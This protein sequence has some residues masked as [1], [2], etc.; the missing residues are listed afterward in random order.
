MINAKTLDTVYI[1]IYINKTKNFV[2][3][4]QGFFA[5]YLNER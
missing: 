5:L 2:S 3:F 1:Y 4:F